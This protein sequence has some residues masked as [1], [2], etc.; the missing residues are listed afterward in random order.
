[1]L[2]IFSFITRLGA[3]IVLFSLTFLYTKSASAQATAPRRP[4]IRLKITAVFP[5]DGNTK[6]FLGSTLLGGGFS[7]DFVD[8][9]N[10]VYKEAPKVAFMYVDITGTTRSRNN[11]RLEARYTGFGAGVRYYPASKKA[12]EAG[13]SL[14]RG[15]LYFGVGLGAYFLTYY[16]KN[17]V[18]N[19][20]IFTTRNNVRFGGKL[21]LGM[22]VGER[23]FVE[24][25]F[26]MPGERHLQTLNASVGLRF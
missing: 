16:Q 11:L 10:V 26:S 6:D 18:L 24:G 19:T 4:P 8:L 7:Y 1:M 3:I 20:E 15:G 9:T 17:E 21:F 12:M 25:D 13:Q 14:E 23:I 2:K 5:T 22:D